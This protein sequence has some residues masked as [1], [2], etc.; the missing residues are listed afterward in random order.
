MR[1]SLSETKKQTALL[2]E[3]G[4]IQTGLL[5]QF[6]L[7]ELLLAKKEAQKLVHD[8]YFQDKKLNMALKIFKKMAGACKYSVRGWAW[9]PGEGTLTR[10]RRYSI[11]YTSNDS[12]DVGNFHRAN[13]LS[14]KLLI[15]GQEC[16]EYC[17]Q[18]NAQNSGEPSSDL[19]YLKLLILKLVDLLN[20]MAQVLFAEFKRFKDDENVIFFVLRH[21]NEINEL[22]EKDWL[23]KNFTEIFPGGLKE[24]REYLH[25]RYTDR[26]FPQ[27]LPIISKFVAAI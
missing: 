15:K 22:F 7:S 23:A 3:E 5:F 8:T 9:S 17:Y 26:N 14:H 25:E 21:N 12:L 20:E 11:A 13:D 24:V 19:N 18:L 4:E 27:L 10:L 2:K 1:F 6:L 16:L